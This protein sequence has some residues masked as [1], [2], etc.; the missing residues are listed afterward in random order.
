MA[1]F[2][3]TCQVGVKSVKQFLEE[4]NFNTLEMNQRLERV[5]EVALTLSSLIQDGVANVNQEWLEWM[6]NLCKGLLFGDWMRLTMTMA[7][8]SSFLN[9]VE[10]HQRADETFKLPSHMQRKV[11][12]I[13]KYSKKCQ[14]ILESTD[15]IMCSLI[16]KVRIH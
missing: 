8:L 16:E 3:K 13:M 4:A 6:R 7:C 10:T 9:L 2:L 12:E 11:D 1:D 15:K 5:N 14:D